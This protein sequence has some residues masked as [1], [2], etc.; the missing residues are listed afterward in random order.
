MAD[1]SAAESH[2]GKPWY[3]TAVVTFHAIP[4]RRATWRRLSPAGRTRLKK[5]LKRLSRGSKLDVW[6]IVLHD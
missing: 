5:A 6:D 2:D 1:A 3:E 4:L